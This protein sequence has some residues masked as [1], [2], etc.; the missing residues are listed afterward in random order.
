[1]QPRSDLHA[2]SAFVLELHE[3]SAC[4]D[5]VA[6]FQW[7]VE[8]LAGEVGADCCWAGWADRGAD[9]IDVCASLSHNLPE[10]FDAFWRGIRHDDLLAR[11]VM[12]DDRAVSFYDRRGG[13]HTEGMIALS[14]RYNIGQMAVVITE[15]EESALSLFLS[16]YR[17]GRRAPPLASSEISFLRHAL[18]HV[19]YLTL[20]DSG[21]DPETGR[22]LVNAQGRVLASTAP[23]RRLIRDRWSGWT[24]RSLPEGLGATSGSSGRQLGT[25]GLHVERRELAARGGGALFGLTLRPLAAIDRLTPREREIAEEIASGRTHKEI[26]RELGL[27]PATIR[28]HTQAILA[29]LGLHNKAMLANVIGGGR[30]S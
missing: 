16:P 9:E 7:S 3:R 23:A 14:D 19:R 6:L 25:Q 12:S 15:Q 5:P 2:F 17:S 8:T 11:D 22:L 28:N 27:S 29:K 26:A 21:D 1:M 13:R 10:D 24:A 18:D 4:L 30:S 20:R